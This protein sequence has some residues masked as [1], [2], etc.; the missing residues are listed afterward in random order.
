MIREKA[1][2]IHNWDYLESIGVPSLPARTSPLDP[3]YDPLTLESHLEQSSHLISAL[4]ISMACWQI[5]DE[6]ATRKKTAAARR[7]NIPV[8]LG[9]GP[10]EVA[11][12]F[13]KVIEY[14]DLCAD[15]GATR[16]EAGQ[17]FTDKDL[18]PIK[19]CGEAARRGLEVQYEIGKKHGRPCAPD[20]IFGMIAT[21]NRWL[22]AGAKQVV[23]EARES[24]INVGLFGANGEFDAVSADRLAE[25][26]GLEIVVFEAPSKQ[27]QFAILNHFGPDVHLCNVRL[28]ELLRVEIYRRGLHAD[29]FGHDNL[30]PRGPHS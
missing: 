2:K 19:I 16:I 25:A 4:K 6:A 27:S 13:D 8:C 23:V 10:F 22:E 12:Y 1:R 14:L 5:A 28:E 21:G 15:L 3:G 26:F 17:G 30:R 20:S 24:A 29:A 11:A 7:L 18:D 9:G